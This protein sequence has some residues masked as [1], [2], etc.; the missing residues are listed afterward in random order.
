L[1]PT[2]SPPL[3]MGAFPLLCSVLLPA[4]DRPSDDGEHRGVSGL[5]PAPRGGESELRLS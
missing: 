4:L 1:P 5:F 2:L 3:A